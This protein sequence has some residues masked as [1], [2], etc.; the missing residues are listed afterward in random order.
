MYIYIDIRM[1]TYTCLYICISIYTH[2]HNILIH[3]NVL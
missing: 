1:D 2:A 3:T